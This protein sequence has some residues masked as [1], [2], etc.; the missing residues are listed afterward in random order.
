MN[1]QA[2][3]VA[4]FA[5]PAG[6]LADE[7]HDTGLLRQGLDRLGRGV[8]RSQRSQQQGGEGK[9]FDLLHGC[10]PSIGALFTF[11]FFY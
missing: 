5:G 10:V 9:R 8:K 1:R 3:P 2:R 7:S 4:H 11:V 6:L